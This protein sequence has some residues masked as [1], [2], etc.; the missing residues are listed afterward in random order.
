MSGNKKIK[1]M[2]TW[3]PHAVS[4]LTTN[5]VNDG[6]KSDEIT[7]GLGEINHTSTLPDDFGM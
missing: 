7:E 3:Q 6:C 4:I 5:N 1:V 2:S